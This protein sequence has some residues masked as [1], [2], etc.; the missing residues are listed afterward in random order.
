MLKLKVL[1]FYHLKNIF[2]RNIESL[3]FQSLLILSF[4]SQNEATLELHLFIDD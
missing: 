4:S 1:F 3:N 2:R